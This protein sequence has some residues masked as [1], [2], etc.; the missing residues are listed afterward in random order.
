MG[1]A[2]GRRPRSGWLVG[3]LTLGTAMPHALRASGRLGPG[4]RSSSASSLL[5]LVG[6]ALVAFLGDGPFAQ[7]RRDN[8]APATR[9]DPG[10]VW[11]VFRVPAFRASAFG[12]FGHMWGALRVLERAA[13]VVPADRG[14]AGA[15]RGGSALRSA[16]QLRRHRRRRRRLRLG[17]QWSRRIG[18]ARVAALALAGSGLMCLLYPLLPEDALGL[19]VAALFFWGFASSPTRRSSLR[20][21][22]GFYAAAAAGQRAWWRRTASAS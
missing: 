5:A 4:R 15:H 8:P 3:M 1:Q 18:G 20:C 13:V 16:A 7:R 14:R 6:A 17:R 9:R 22:R 12:Y 21:H 2:P 19:R 10:A 11:R